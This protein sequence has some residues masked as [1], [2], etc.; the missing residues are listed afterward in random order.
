M[1]GVRD[2][3]ELK[4]YVQDVFNKKEEAANEADSGT[5]ST[6]SD[7]SNN[8]ATDNSPNGATSSEP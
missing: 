1:L 6:S 4:A 3:D 8:S 7:G 2:E 5:S